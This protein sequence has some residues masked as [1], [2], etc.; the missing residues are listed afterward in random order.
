MT[1]ENYPLSDLDSLLSKDKITKDDLLQLPE[2]FPEEPKNSSSKSPL[3]HEPGDSSHQP[4]N[5]Q[6]P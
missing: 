6:L 2:L 5:L 4:T 3:L 1:Q